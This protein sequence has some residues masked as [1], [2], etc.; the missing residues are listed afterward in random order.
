MHRPGDKIDLDDIEA[1]FPGISKKVKFIE[2]PL[3][4]ISSNQIRKLIAQ[5]KPFRYYLPMEVFLIIV[6]HNLYKIDNGC[7]DHLPHNG[8]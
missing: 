2:A 7:D 5:N 3:L 6:K 1:D 4:E 8:K